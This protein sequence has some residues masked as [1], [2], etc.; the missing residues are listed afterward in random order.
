MSQGFLT[1]I[2]L[3]VFLLLVALLICA[4]RPLSPAALSGYFGGGRVTTHAARS[5][6]QTLSSKSIVVDTLNLAHWLKRKHAPSRTLEL[7]DIIAAI[8][9]TAPLLRHR[10]TDRII[11]VTKDRETRDGGAESTRTLYKLAA[12]RNRVYIHLVER[13]EH[14]EKPKKPEKH[15]TLGRDD[16]YLILI[17]S[18]LNCPVL[19]RDRFRDLAD[20]KSGHLAKFHVYSYTPLQ[21]WPERNYVNPAAADFTRVRRPITVDYSEALPLL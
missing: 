12:H 18:R 16:F 20:M 11:Y 5:K 2:V 13:Y 3:I 19:S 10:Y 14:L 9:Q 21:P 4:D 7:R 1:T 6:Q 8:D 17:A 15:A